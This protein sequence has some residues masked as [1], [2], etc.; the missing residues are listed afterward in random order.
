MNLWFKTAFVLMFLCLSFESSAQTP[1]DFRI[2]EQFFNSGNTAMA[3]GEYLLAIDDFT[4]ALKIYPSQYPIYLNR[5]LSYR[6][7]RKYELAIKD[8]ETILVL[9]PN[10]ASQT[11]AEI[12]STLGALHQENSDLPRALENINKALTIDS[13]N[14]KIYINRAN[15]YILLSNIDRALEDFNKSIEL[16]P[17]SLAYYGR[18]KLFQQKQ[19]FER[20][21]TDY[22][23]AIDMSPSFAEAYNNRGLL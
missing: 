3:R 4:K 14:P 10:L 2:A 1:E 16:M 23:N 6:N 8:F 12:Y 17:T 7:L 5:G 18:A 13:S 9:N 15:T 19:N 21:V 11:W 20:A 22:S